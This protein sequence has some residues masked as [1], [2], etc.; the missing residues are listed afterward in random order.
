[1]S[2]GRNVENPTD[3]MTNA[4]DETTR[5]KRMSNN[6]GRVL[7]K[8]QMP[9]KEKFEMRLPKDAWII[10]TD[11]QDGLLWMWAVVDTRHELETRKFYAV[12]CGGNVPEIE[13]LVYLGFCPVF[14]QQEIALYIFEDI[15]PNENS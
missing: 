14:V 11:F 5:G 3:N 9:L 10:R 12:K 13:N 7:F 8:Y 15:T 1:M 4:W 2:L 6:S